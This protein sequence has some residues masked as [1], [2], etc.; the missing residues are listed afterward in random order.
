M[1]LETLQYLFDLNGY[2]VIE[3]VLG[4]SEI[5]ALEAGID[6]QDL[7]PPNPKFPRFGSAGAPCAPPAPGFSSTGNPSST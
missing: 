3:N 7:D 1:D 6:T 4:A 2:V 5:A